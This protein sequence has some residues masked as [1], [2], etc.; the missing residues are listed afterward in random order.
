MLAK[1]SNYPS[2][3]DDS[4]ISLGDKDSEFLGGGSQV[5]GYNFEPEFSAEEL[6]LTGLWLQL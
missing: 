2:S 6:W 1:M 5:F 3:S 4:S